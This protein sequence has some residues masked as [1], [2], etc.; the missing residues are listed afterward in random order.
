MRWQSPVRPGFLPSATGFIYYPPN[1][2]G[3][4]HK[5]P[6]DSWP[7]VTETLVALAIAA[8]ATLLSGECFAAQIWLMWFNQPEWGC[9]YGLQLDTN[10]EISCIAKPMKRQ[11]NIWEGSNITV[12]SKQKTEMCFLPTI[13][14]LICFY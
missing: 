8:T 4:F 11:N 6:P 1:F 5:R 3:I 14:S 12:V 7:V 13:C 10:W 2:G 9:Y